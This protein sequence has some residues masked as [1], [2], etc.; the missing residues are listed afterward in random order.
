[1]G[2]S[3]GSSSTIRPEGQGIVRRASWLLTG[4]VIGDAGM[5]VYYLLLARRFGAAGIGDYSFAFAVGS[6]LMLA[7]SFGLRD[8]LTRR[9]ARDPDEVPRIAPT[10]VIT[11]ATITL[12]LLGLLILVAR[13]IGYSSTM[14]GYLSL[15][16]LSL[17]LLVI[18]IT[19]TSFL[20]AVGAMNLSAVAA[21]IQKTVIMVPGI[22]LI[23]SGA[24]LLA[25]L[26]AHVAAG[27]VFVFVGWRWTRRRFG[28]FRITYHP[29]LARTLF[30]AALPFLATSALWE[31]YSRVDI[32]MLHFF[33][34]ETATGMY[35]AAY[36][37]IAA[38]L[39]VP[40]LIG[41]ALFPT[42]ARGL[43]THRSETQQIYRNT[44]RALTVLG[45][46]G[47]ILIATAGDGLQVTLFGSEFAES[48]RLIR[49]MAPLFVVQF[50]MVPLWRL[51]LAM[52]QERTLVKLRLGSV[53]LNVGLNLVLIPK[54][55]ALGAIFTSLI[56]EG[57]LAV[58]QFALCLRVIRS[59]FGGRGL[60]LAGAGLAGTAVGFFARAVMAWPLA[61]IVALASF[62]AI[63]FGLR[64]VLPSEVRE[65][66]R[67]ARLKG[68]GA[69]EVAGA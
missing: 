69:E 49:L 52:D 38:P 4:R 40:E 17:A 59:P 27:V 1:M 65:V 39:F 32:V 18:G 61:A 66:L 35:A 44:V 43:V 8:L 26:C 62:C 47:G 57:L 6:M 20:E 41:I 15:A 28:H 37:V 24:S 56:S 14:V 53:A 3:G 13:W 5:F 2:D 46:A 12:L 68:E 54:Y 45:L 31:I 51:L 64:L 67:Q 33:S 60:G 58:A 23:A 55:G 36:K 22:A 21:L 50:L 19:F 11:Q 48:G 29:E 30:M 25:V 42:L 10:V 63:V 16:F 7:V 9:V 34:G